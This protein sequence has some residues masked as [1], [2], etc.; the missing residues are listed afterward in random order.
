MAA[1]HE[2]SAEPLLTSILDTL[3]EQIVSGA[4]EPGH[5]FTLQDLS[6]R[7]GISRTVAREVMRALEQL[8]LV[9]SSRLSLIH[10]SEP[11][12]RHHVSRMPSSA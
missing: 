9:S 2:P 4:L 8:G 6:N 3:G 10:I 12:R 1:P 5:T 11:T 7:F